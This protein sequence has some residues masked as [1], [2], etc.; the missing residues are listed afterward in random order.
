VGLLDENDYSRMM[1]DYH[2]S[3]TV[4]L[5]N[6]SINRDGDF[7][8]MFPN[9]IQEL[10]IYKCSCDVSSL[11]KY[12]TDLEVIKIWDSNSIESL[13]SSSWFYSAPLPLPSYNG[14]FSGLKEFNCY[15]CRSMKKLFPILLLPYLVNLKVI[16]VFYCEKMEEI[17]GTRSDEE[18]VMV[19][20]SSSSSS[21]FK[22]PKLRNLELR[23]LPELKSICSAKLVC[24]SLQ[25]IWIAN[26]QKLKRMPICLPLLEND[27]P[28]ALP[29][30]QNIFIYPREW[31][32]YVVEWDHPN[33]KNVLHPFVKFL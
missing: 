29:S 4:A 15:G 7:Q 17:V 8:V 27:Q 30:L 20:E 19:E 1:D 6:L 3:K 11:I 22:L 21:E 2:T 24:D 31:W 16:R 26:C 33:A 9:D 13:V 14:I 18:A 32:E 12:A 5:C 23:G 10:V 25:H 28:S